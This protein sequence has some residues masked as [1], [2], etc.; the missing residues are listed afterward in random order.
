MTSAMNT[1]ESARM[2]TAREAAFRIDRPNA[3]PRAVHVFALDDASW[4]LLQEVA[5]LPW[6]RAAFFAARSFDTDTP[7]P[8]QGASFS[9]WLQ[10][11][12][13]RTRDLVAEVGRADVVV[14]VATAGHDAGQDSRMASI[15]GEACRAQGRNGAGIVLRG[16]ATAAEEAGTMARMRPHVRMLVAAGDADYLTQMLTAL[17]A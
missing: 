11:L 4:R 17:R 9:A 6:T 15:I 10:D 16:R 1:S 13:G 7:A 5:G 12:A 3:L 14:L 2:T 8:A